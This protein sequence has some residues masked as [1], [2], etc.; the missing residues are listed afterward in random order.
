MSEYRFTAYNLDNEIVSGKITALN[1]DEAKQIIKN[2]NYTLSKIKEVKDIKS[3]VITTKI[4]N[5][6]TLLICEKLYMMS[7][8]GI[9]LNV[10]FDKIKDTFHKK[11]INKA[12]SEVASRLNSGESLNKVL[13]SN[14]KVFQRYF[15][16]MLSL[17]EESGD[18]VE[19]LTN[20]IDY[21]K[22]KIDYDKKFESVL[23]YPVVLVFLAVTILICLV[24]III[25]SFKSIFKDMRL[26]IP[27]I[28]LMIFNIT[29]FLDKYGLFIILG[30]ILIATLIVFLGNKTSLKPL[31]D[32]WKYKG[33]FSK[34]VKIDCFLQLFRIMNTLLL[35]G[36]KVI[37][38][39]IASC[40][41]I[42]NKYF[43]TQLDLCI[44]EIERGIPL[45][46]SLKS[47][48][49]F[50]SIIIESLEISEQ[51]NNLN[52]SFNQLIELYE[53]ERLGIIDKF[54]ALIE[55]LSIIF[56]SFIVV[57]IVACVYIPMF[58]MFDG[59]L[60]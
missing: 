19:V 14:S 1:I 52:L 45:S 53:N 8:A 17:T 25:P 46:T 40:K 36:N 38:A 20:L 55:P 18:V 5:K 12:L 59:L 32:R 51:T 7:K 29:D 50:D 2:Y 21:Y 16:T 41:L 10:A 27:P 22:H 24:K 56:I 54:M 6:D 30:T 43:T 42:S 39:M 49:L 23:T 13:N 37:T 11:N 15:I 9:T 3:F 34:L 31:F 33:L 44:K 28:T 48:T 26:D 58:N 4:S 57:L 35:S 60:I 47:T